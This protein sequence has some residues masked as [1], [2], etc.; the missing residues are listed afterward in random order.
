MRR[1]DLA[2]YSDGPEPR[3]TVAA[4]RVRTE[5]GV[6]VDGGSTHRCRPTLGG[7]SRG[8]RSRAAR[9]VVDYG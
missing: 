2:G 4:T 7:G 5:L 3:K 1:R 9:E 6:S 8:G